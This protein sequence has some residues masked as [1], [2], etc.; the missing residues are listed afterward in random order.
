MGMRIGSG[1]CDTMTLGNGPGEVGALCLPP[2]VLSSFVVIYREMRVAVP[3]V[4]Y[5]QEGW[6]GCVTSRAAIL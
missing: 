6:D 5:S 1:C 4:Q 3:W 2:N